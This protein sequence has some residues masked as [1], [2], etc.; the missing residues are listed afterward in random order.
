MVQNQNPNPN[1]NI[2]MIS[3]EPREAHIVVVIRGGIVIGAD[4]NTQQGQPQV[5]PVAQKKALLDVQKEKEVFLE[6]WP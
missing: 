2:L 5:R 6:V 1:L 3:S 4:Q